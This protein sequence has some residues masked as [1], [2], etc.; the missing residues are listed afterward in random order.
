MTAELLN[1]SRLVWLTVSVTFEI[2][3]VKIGK[4]SI[5]MCQQQI[6]AQHPDKKVC[7]TG[8]YYTGISFICY[9]SLCYNVKYTNTTKIVETVVETSLAVSKTENYKHYT[10]KVVFIANKLY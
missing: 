4:I 9:Y 1:S 3:S 6:K 2:G 5:K 10:V 8:L 7:S